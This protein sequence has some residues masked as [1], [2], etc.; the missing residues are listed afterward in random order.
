M[1]EN[2]FLSLAKERSHMF[3]HNMQVGGISTTAIYQQ[4]DSSDPS[5]HISE[6]RCSK[7][8]VPVTPGAYICAY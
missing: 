2:I 3:S 5:H 1:E 7:P 6:A 8:P 4:V